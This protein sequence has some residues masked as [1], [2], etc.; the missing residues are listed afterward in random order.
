MRA[1]Y[2]DCF[3]GISGDM[4]LAA[5]ADAGADMDYVVREL[6]KLPLDPYELKQYTVNKRGITAVKVDVELSKEHPPVHHRHYRDIVHMIQAAEF[7]PEVERHALS[8]F[9]KIGIAEGKIHGLSLDKVHFHEVGAVDS[10]VDAVGVAL[11]LHTLQV[12]AVIS[13]P[14]PTGYGFVRCDHGLYPVPAPA[15][16]EMLKGIPIA[17][18]VHRSELTTPTGAGIVSALVSHFLA[19][20]PSMKI[21]K[22]GYGAGSRDLPDQPNVLRVLIGE[23]SKNELDRCVHREQHHLQ[24]SHHHGHTHGHGNHHHD[25]GHSHEHDHD[26]EHNHHHDH[27]HHDHSHSHEHHEHHHESSDEGSGHDHH[28]HDHDK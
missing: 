22:I 15:T 13:S 9:E 3:S 17:H 2:L 6:Q 23:L 5:L 7:N 25:H 12:E 10:I 1:I 19:S 14:I 20:I 27:E 26:H 18:T 21:E 16:L 28:H 4:T 11:A 24:H 8:I